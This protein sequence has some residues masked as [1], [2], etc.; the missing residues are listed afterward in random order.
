MENRK[1]DLTQV[2]MSDDLAALGEK[3]KH[4][5]DARRPDVEEQSA[6]WAIGIR[7][8]SEFA[9]AVVVGGLFGYAIDHFAGTK[10]WALLLGV[11][12][13]F[14][15][16]TRNIVRLAKELSA[17]VPIGQDSTEDDDDAVWPHEDN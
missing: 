8:A 15:A 3:L 4:A 11:L 10:P 2:D 7:Y 5:Q 1:P 17:G 13:G 14:A 16:G 6:G 12:F 9:S